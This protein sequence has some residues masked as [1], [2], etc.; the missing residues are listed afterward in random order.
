VN[1]GVVRA[2]QMIQKACNQTGKNIKVDGW[3]GPKTRGA[4]FWT[5]PETLLDKFV[6]ERIET[7]VELVRHNRKFNK[8]LL[9]WIN[10]ALDI[11]NMNEGKK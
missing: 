3:I 7:Y 1:H 5:N 2:A 6:I 11:Y 9:G 10:R 4:I 8:F